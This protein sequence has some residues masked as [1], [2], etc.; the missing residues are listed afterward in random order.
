[1]ALTR[2]RL[3]RAIEVTGNATGDAPV[4]LCLLDQIPLM[5]TS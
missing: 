2:V 3:N 1:L 5:K 4:L